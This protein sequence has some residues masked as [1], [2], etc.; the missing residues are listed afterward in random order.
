MLSMLLIE[1]AVKILKGRHFL[2]FLVDFGG[3]LSQG[4]LRSY[5][6]ASLGFCLHSKQQ[7]FI[8]Q[9]LRLTAKV[10]FTSEPGF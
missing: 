8:L 7:C 1:N 10:K 6:E 2:S 9:R 4:A 3:F 5:L